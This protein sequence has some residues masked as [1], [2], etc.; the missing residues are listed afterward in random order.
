MAYLPLI[1]LAWLWFRLIDHLRVEW[2]VNPQYAYGWAVPFLCAYLLWKGLRDHGPVGRS[3]GEAEDGVSVKRCFGGTKGLGDEGAKGLGDE[4]AKGLRDEGSKGLGPVFWWFGFGLLAFLYLPTR[5]IEEANPEW[6]LVSWA[7]A[8]EVVG[9]TLLVGR[10]F[11]GSVFRC[12]GETVFRWTGVSVGRWG[13]GAVSEALK[14]CSTEILVF[15]VCFFLVAV[16]WP[17][18]IE[19]PVVQGLMRANAAVTVGLIG[20]LGIPAIQHGNVIEVATGMVG[21]DE[22]CSGIR[23]LQATLMISLFLGELY[24][25]SLARRLVCVGAGVALSFVFNVSRTSL[26]TLVAASQGV[27]AIASWHD[28]AGIT[29]LVW[30]FVLLWFLAMVLAGVISFSRAGPRDHGAVGQSGGASVFRCFGEPVF[31]CFGG[32]VGRCFGG[33]VFRW[34]G[35]FLLGWLVVVE[36]GTEVWDRAHEWGLPRAVAWSI[37]SAAG[38]GGVPGGAV[39]GEDEAVAAL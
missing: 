5:L 23:S 12:F 10:C 28:P 18:F 17:T 14:H 11:G 26:L 36:G 35:V 3:G 9:I 20:A 13:G 38:E 4:G 19:A 24:R 27:A 21:I 1:A 7:L 2:A 29:I 39:L 6:R 32:A 8:L 34:G 16:P 31:R 30:C 37:E 15:P 25:L 33:A 22:A